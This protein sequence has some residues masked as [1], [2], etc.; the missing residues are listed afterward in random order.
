MGNLADWD[1]ISFWLLDYNK[2]RSIPL[3]EFRTCF[4]Q[5]NKQTNKQTKDRKYLMISNYQSNT[6][7]FWQTWTNETVPLQHTLLSSQYC[8]QQNTNILFSIGHT[9]RY[10]L[11]SSN[12]WAAETNLES[13][14]DFFCQ[15]HYWLATTTIVDLH[16]KILVARLEGVW[17]T[18][19]LENWAKN[20]TRISFVYFGISKWQYLELF[21]WSDFCK[22]LQK[23]N[24][25]KL[26]TCFISKTGKP[27]S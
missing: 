17:W 8:G 27:L 12:P 20:K 19:L 18:D 15:T 3:T 4:K 11:I 5:T 26:L 9:N 6:I 14:R 22:P 23:F 25:N 21:C 7:Y 13:I 10:R 24:V 1:L 16:L 2:P